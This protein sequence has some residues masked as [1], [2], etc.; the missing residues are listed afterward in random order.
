MTGVSGLEL[1]LVSDGSPLLQKQALQFLV[2]G[3][4]ME[5]DARVHGAI[6]DVLADLPPGRPSQDALDAALRTAIERNRSLT[7]SVVGSRD[8]RIL[9][10]KK[11]TL[12]KFGIIDLERMDEEIPAKVLA[13]LSTEQYLAL[14][15]S[16]HGLFER[17]DPPEDVQLIALST[18]LQTLVARG[19]T[20][21]DFKDIY[22]ENCD[23]STAKS[24]ERAI[25]DGAYL[26][27]A[28][29][30]KVSLRGV[31]FRG[32]DLGGTIFF[33]AD[34]TNSDLRAEE[35]PPGTRA[36]DTGVISRCWNVRNSV[37]P[38]S[39]VGHWYYS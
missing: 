1:F 2:N 8:R 12:A 17:L 11:K 24:L 7:K 4:S 34:L 32:A 30:A 16:E 39:P 5:T 29:F 19:A 13:A 31:S 21:A 22:C 36:R 3:L 37:G 10:E 6:L 28:N 27:D 23:F 9:Q 25:F 35:M 18:A 20:S 38:I 33:G 26:G 15:D 14:L